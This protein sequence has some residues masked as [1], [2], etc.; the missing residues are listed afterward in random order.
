M[1]VVTAWQFMSERCQLSVTL[2]FV[3]IAIFCVIILLSGMFSEIFANI[4]VCVSLVI[5]IVIAIVLILFP[6]GP[7]RGGS[8]SFGT[9]RWLLWSVGPMVTISRAGNSL[10]G[11]SATCRL[12]Y[13][14]SVGNILYRA[15]SF[16]NCTVHLMLSESYRTF[17]PIYIVTCNSI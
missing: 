9:D 16:K 7:L 11:V 5:R 15:V 1:T 4:I 14:P 17:S 3:L 2:S 10:L 13:R 12:S 6:L 8:H